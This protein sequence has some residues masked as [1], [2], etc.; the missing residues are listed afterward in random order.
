MAEAG[1]F[2]TFGI[3]PDRPETGY[4]YIRRGDPLTAA[5]GAFA[6]SGYEIRA[7]AVC[8]TTTK[9]TSRAEIP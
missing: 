6:V 2:V 7:T 3:E 5:D 9:A 8:Q 4:G 1:Y